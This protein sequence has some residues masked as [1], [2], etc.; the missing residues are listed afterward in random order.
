[1]D[2]EKARD[3]SQAFERLARAQI[4]DSPDAARAD[5]ETVITHPFQLFRTQAAEALGQAKSPASVPV[6]AM[7]LNDRSEHV[8]SAAA[9]ALA[10]IG[11]PE[12]LEVLRCA[13]VEDVVE[14]PNYLANAI[15]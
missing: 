5:L 1:M 4:S 14:R 15:A 13:F 9:H 12:A 2:E 8:A 11:T 6:L 10:N 3:R 7:A